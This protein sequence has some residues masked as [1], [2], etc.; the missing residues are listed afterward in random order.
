M[1]TREVLKSGN[2]NF[3]SRKLATVSKMVFQRGTHRGIH[4][5]MVG[6]SDRSAFREEL[7]SVEV[8]LLD[9][10]IVSNIGVAVTKHCEVFFFFFSHWKKPHLKRSD[11]FAYT[12]LVVELRVL[13]KY[14]R[15]LEDT[16]IPLVWINPSHTA[17][18]PWAAWYTAGE[19][20][21]RRKHCS[22][23]SVFL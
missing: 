8:I 23:C 7:S 14:A 18:E 9:C 3:I 4:S 19:S 6:S 20:R 11:Y 5:H 10:I 1:G 21:K 17:D 16:R 12:F 22:C 2:G 13:S 15:L